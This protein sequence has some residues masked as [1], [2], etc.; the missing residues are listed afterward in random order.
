[1]TQK[2]V[3]VFLA[4]GFEEVE[5]FTPIDYLRR[6]EEI[7]VITV[8]VGGQAVEGSHKISTVADTTLFSFDIEKA[9]MI[10]LPGGMPGTLNLEASDGVKAAIRRAMERGIDVAA[11]CAAPSI[12]GHMGY[13]KGKTATCAEGFE[14]ELTGAICTGEPVEVDGNI[15]TS[16]GA[17]V[18]NQFAF[19]L[20]ERLLG[21]ARAEKLKGAVRWAK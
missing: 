9:D 6:C 3:Y 8:G 12:L 1:M 21:K 18:A 19:M 14:Q 17:G 7:T 5:A 20:V 11:I 2:L 16:R 13:L 4:N 10:L 15:I